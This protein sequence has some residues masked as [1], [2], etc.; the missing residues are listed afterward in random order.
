MIAVGMRRLRRVPR[1]ATGSSHRKEN[2]ISLP[3]ELIDA[4]K[5]NRHRNAE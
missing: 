3:V 1:I 4:V 5:A 2:H